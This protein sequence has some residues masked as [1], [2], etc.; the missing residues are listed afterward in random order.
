MFNKLLEVMQVNVAD[1]S[2]FKSWFQA[3]HCKTCHTHQ[4]QKEAW[5]RSGGWQWKHVVLP[6]NKNLRHSYPLPFARALARC[7]FRSF[8][9]WVI[10]DEEYV[11]DDSLLS[12]GRDTQGQPFTLT[13]ITN[14][15]K[16]IDRNQ[17]CKARLSLYPMLKRPNNQPGVHPVQES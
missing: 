8:V 3:W 15:V 9:I 4:Q 1:K 2:V 7:S 5:P 11:K 13:S 10:V 17:P 6:F 12:W 16:G 14:C